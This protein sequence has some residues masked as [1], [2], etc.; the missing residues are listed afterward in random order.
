MIGQTLFCDFVAVTMK[1]C[2]RL[3]YPQ[4]NI[5]VCTRLMLVQ[6]NVTHC[7]ASERA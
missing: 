5:Y 3:G 7:L 6:G 1:G 2:G 4:A